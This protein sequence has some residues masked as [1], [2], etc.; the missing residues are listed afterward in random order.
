MYCHMKSVLPPPWGV[1]E[2]KHKCPHLQ[3]LIL[4]QWK[5]TNLLPPE[6]KAKHIW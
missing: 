6:T 3:R 1:Q 2:K 4:K 5:W